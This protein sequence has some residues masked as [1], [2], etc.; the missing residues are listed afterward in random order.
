MR[1]ARAFLDPE[2]QI[3]KSTPEAARRQFL[4]QDVGLSQAMATEEVERY[5][6]RSPGRP[7]RTSTATR[8]LE[9]RAEAEKQL[10]QRSS[11]ARLPRLR[12]SRQGLLPPDL[13]RKAVLAELRQ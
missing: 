4:K 2:L 12:S 6:F 7:R 9:L 11:T 10:G 13:M 5:T 3:G 8:L 1:A